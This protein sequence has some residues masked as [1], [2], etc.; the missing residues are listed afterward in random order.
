MFLASPGCTVGFDV[1]VGALAERDRLQPLA[2]G[3]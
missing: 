1:T 2:L 3:F